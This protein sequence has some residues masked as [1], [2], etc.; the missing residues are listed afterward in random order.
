MLRSQLP[1]FIRASTRAYSTASRSASF[2]GYDALRSSVSSSEPSYTFD[3]AHADAKFTEFYREVQHRFRPLDIPAKFRHLVLRPKNL[4]IL[5]STS[6]HVTDKAGNTLR[7]SEV[8]LARP[9]GKLLMRLIKTA[10]VETPEEAIEAALEEGE[11]AEANLL[12]KPVEKIAAVRAIFDRYIKKYPQQLLPEHLA[13][14]LTTAAKGSALYPTRSYIFDSVLP[15]APQLLDIT[16]AREALRIYAIRAVVVPKVQTAK[17]LVRLYTTLASLLPEK[18]LDADAQA[19]WIVLYGL[20]ATSAK[21]LA[22]PFATRA[23]ALPT[24]LAIPSSSSPNKRVPP[25][26]RQYM[27]DAQLATV[28]VAAGGAPGLDDKKLAESL[29]AADKIRNKNGLGEFP[30][31]RYVDQVGRGILAETEAERARHAPATAEEQEEE[32]VQEEEK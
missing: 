12:V 30:F 6:E 10:S 26:I 15:K 29:K 2:A 22:A 19:Q 23:A 8:I 7:D 17:D 18:S 32:P 13:A 20:N 25:G 27:F 16:V 21:D 3:V 31:A 11:E 14:L 5:R 28:A 4:T 9:S 1:G 24:D